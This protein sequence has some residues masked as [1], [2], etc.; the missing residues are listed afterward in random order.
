MA[1]VVLSRSDLNLVLVCLISCDI[2]YLCY[3]SRLSFLCYAQHSFPKLLCLLFHVNMST[4]SSYFDK[5]SLSRKT[6]CVHTF[7]ESE[8]KANTDWLHASH[9]VVIFSPCKIPIPWKIHHV[10]PRDKICGALP[11]IAINIRIPFLPHSSAYVN[12]TSY[13]YW[14]SNEIWY[15][16]M[17]CRGIFWNSLSAY[18][19]VWY[20]IQNIFSHWPGEYPPCTGCIFATTVYCQYPA[21]L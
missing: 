4:V 20:P 8:V 6:K 12:Y 2:L 9:A 15:L 19:L 18:T 14:H 13:N 3:I 10:M 7:K 5:H 17:E 11:C 1:W 21:G 16:W